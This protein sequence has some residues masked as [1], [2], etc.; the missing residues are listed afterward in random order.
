MAGREQ[1][2]HRGLPIVRAQLRL[3]VEGTSERGGSGEGRK[4]GQA[5]QSTRNLLTQAG[6]GKEM[7]LAGPGTP[8]PRPFRGQFPGRGGEG[9][10]LLPSHSLPPPRPIPGAA[11]PVGNAV[12]AAGAQPR[13][14][15]ESD[16]A[17]AAAAVRV[18]RW[19]AV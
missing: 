4:E 16:W 18:L 7:G 8:M 19:A 1:P 3:K 17:A 9:R 11:P 13:G 5:N 15:Q 6:T 2:G 10:G 12:A 14:C